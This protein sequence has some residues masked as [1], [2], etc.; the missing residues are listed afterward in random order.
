MFIKNLRRAMYNICFQ[1]MVMPLKKKK[2]GQ[3]DS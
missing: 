2:K 3:D 1:L